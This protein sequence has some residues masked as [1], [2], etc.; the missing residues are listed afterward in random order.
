MKTNF[1]ILSF[2]FHVYDVKVRS[3]ENFWCVLWWISIKRTKIYNMGVPSLHP[4][5]SLISPIP[6][7]MQCH[8][9]NTFTKMKSGQFVSYQIYRYNFLQCELTWKRNHTYKMVLSYRRVKCALI[10]MCR[11]WERFSVKFPIMPMVIRF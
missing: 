5:L 3:H 2:F 9:W 4:L 7:S 8:I 10:L 11:F 1:T 6:S